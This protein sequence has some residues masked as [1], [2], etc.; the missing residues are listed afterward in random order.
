LTGNP[1]INDEIWVEILEGEKKDFVMTC[2]AG[3]FF[4]GS[5]LLDSSG[6]VGSHAYSLLSALEVKTKDGKTIQLVKL[7]NPWG[8]SEWQYDWSDNSPLWT[9]ELKAQVGFENRDDGI[10]YMAF[11][12]FLK[13]FSDVQ[14]CKVHD[15]YTYKALRVKASPN[16]ATYFKLTVKKAGHYYLTANQE[17]KRKHLPSEEYKYSEIAIV[18]AKKNGKDYEYVEGF[19]RTDKEVWTDGELQ[20]GEYIVYIKVDWT[21]KQDKDFSFGVYGSGDVSIEKV[22]KSYC[23]DFLAKTYQYKGRTSKKLEDYAYYNVANCYRAVELTDDGFGFVYYK[24]DSKVT[25]DEEL[26]FKVMEG[27]KLRKP[28]RGNCIKITVK[29][30]EEK[31]VVT[32][33]IPEAKRIRQ[34]FTEK[35]KFS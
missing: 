3:D 16:H 19:A 26:Y 20:P 31:C 34:A 22:P 25:L 11:E 15:E 28:Y 14:I 24:N 23:P 35:V 33:V 7:R 8:Q 6:L 17:S 18:F 30:G 27:L 1:N 4:E 12:D 13:Y 5:D 9:P 29:P 10:F 21:Q 2:G 32:K